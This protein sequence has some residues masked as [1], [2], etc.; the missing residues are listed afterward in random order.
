MNLGLNLSFAIK[1]LQD[2]EELAK[3]C[4]NEFK[5]DRVQFTWDLIDPWWPE[6]QRSELAQRYKESFKKY[7]ISIDAT[8]GGLAAYSYPQLLSSNEIQRRIS[9]EFFKR[10]ID[11]TIELGSDIIGTPIG[12][13][14]YIDAH[15]VNRRDYL[16]NRAIED[17]REIAS[18][19]EKKGI[20]EIHIEATPLE[21]EF[22]H[23]PEDTL[24]F[25]SDIENT[26]QIPV[27]MLIDWGH[28]LYK[29]LLKEKADMIYWLNKCKRYIGSIHIQQTDGL[30]DRHWDFTMPGIVTKEKIEESLNIFELNHIIQYLEV[31]PAF[32][33]NSDDVFNKIKYSMGYLSDIFHK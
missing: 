27:K 17:I 11:L 32:E 10:A 26:T 14:S 2:P 15:S 12:G 25:M 6:L 29:P 9:V 13:M 3:K 1:R 24:Q 31:V 20:R 19:G 16:Y 21:S 5:T 22:P 18:Y 33:E 8:F 28:A 7:G 30:F 4:K 23:S